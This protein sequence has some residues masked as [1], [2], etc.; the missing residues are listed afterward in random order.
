MEITVATRIKAP[1][2]RVWAAWN[3]PRA[4]EQWNAASPD[5]HTPRASVDLR[6]GG[7]LLARMEA[8]DGSAGF[9]FG[10]TYTRIEPQR[11]IEYVMDDERRVRVDFLACGEGTVVIETF[12]AENV[13]PPEHQRAGWQAILDNFAR[14][15]EGPSRRDGAAAGATG[16]RAVRN[17]R[18]LP[19]SAQAVYDAFATPERLACWWGPEGFRNT[20]ETFE[21]R[22]GGRWT[23]VM[24]GP[25][26]TDHPNHCRFEELD[27]GRRIVIRHEDVPRFTLTVR[28]APD[29]DGTHL[30]WGQTFDEVRVADALR[31]FVLV[32][33][34]QNLDR[35][36]RVLADPPHATHPED[37]T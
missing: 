23:F 31:P 9:D 22:P 25:D 30:D 1:L 32:A 18:H 16:E 19:A 24:H 6:V 2:A 15:V 21:F 14:H 5:W 3:D 7:R 27:P 17:A 10:A 29:G 28:L 34:E 37:L 36:T 12:E 33:N 35:L 4:M 8:R 11:C 13:W 26:G 20:F